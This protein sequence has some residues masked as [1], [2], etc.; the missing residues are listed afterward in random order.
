[1][2]TLSILRFLVILAVSG[3]GSV[4]VSLKSSE[5]VSD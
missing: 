4:S 2:T 3:M 1:M 5:K